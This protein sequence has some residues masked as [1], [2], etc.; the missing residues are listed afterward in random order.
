MALHNKTFGSSAIASA[1]WDDETS[2]LTI[3]FEGRRGSGLYSFN[4]FPE[5]EWQRFIE[6]HSAGSFYNTYIKGRYS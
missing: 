6:A 2:E 1:V 5:H 4:A 3:E